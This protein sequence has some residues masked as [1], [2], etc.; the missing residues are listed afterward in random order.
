M[1]R[2]RLALRWLGLVLIAGVCLARPPACFGRGEGTPA[3]RDAPYAQGSSRNLL[4]IYRTSTTKR[5]PVVVFFHGGEWHKGDKA[6]VRYK[7]SLFTRA[8]YVFVSVGYRLVPEVR[9]P[10]QIEDVARA[11]GW[12]HRNIAQY[13]GDP[14][15]IVL[16][17]HSSGAHLAALLATDERY[18]QA[19]GASL[20]HLRAALCVDGSGY[21]I[22]RLANLPQS[23]T[24][25]LV[26]AAFG[27]D[28][29]VQ[30]DASPIE[31]VAPGKGIPPML[32]AWTSWEASQLQSDDFANALRHSGIEVETIF[33]PNATHESIIQDLGE[34]GNDL[35]T[36]V[37]EFIFRHIR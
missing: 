16:L 26:E 14:D 25:A 27:V 9:H 30:R 12:V 10:M 8:G 19:A 36:R 21:D 37:L 20:H 7:P 4:D 6:H 17:G 24:R 5:A 28:P 22:L 35:T 32:L 23:S 29:Q 13:G 34:P 1:A 3:E 33:V 18:L 2:S 11:V 15:R 31:H